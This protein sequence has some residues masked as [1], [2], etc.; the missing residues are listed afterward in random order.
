M[1]QAMPMPQ[2]NRKSAPIE[3]YQQPA[4]SLPEIDGNP[5]IALQRRLA[6]EFGAAALLNENAFPFPSRSKARI[7]QVVS[8]VS[9]AAGPVLLGTAVLLLIKVL[10]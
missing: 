2:L 1:K 3:D 8:T 7:E 6:R 4:L 5:A 9:R 10:A